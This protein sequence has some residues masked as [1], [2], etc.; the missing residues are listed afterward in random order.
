MLNPS[1]PCFATAKVFPP[2]GQSWR[3]NCDINRLLPLHSSCWPSLTVTVPVIDSPGL[4]TSLFLSNAISNSWT[5]P[6]SVRNHSESSPV[7]TTTTH[8]FTTFHSRPFAW[9]H[10]LIQ[11]EKDDRKFC[12]SIQNIFGRLHTQW[13]SK[14]TIL[15]LFRAQKFQEYFI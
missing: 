8:T 1:L 11:D 12:I 9:R 13:R 10:W 6:M 3:Y 2:Y 7:R 5:F 14:W 15:S 4:Y